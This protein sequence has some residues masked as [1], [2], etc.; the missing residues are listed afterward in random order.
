LPEIGGIEIGCWLARDYW[1]R[2]LATEAARVVMRDGFERVGLGRIVAI[3]QPA[4]RASIRIMH[5]LEMRCEGMCSLRG[6]PVVM[7]ARE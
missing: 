7:Y 3:A 2:G 5:K 1:G 6:I 4:N